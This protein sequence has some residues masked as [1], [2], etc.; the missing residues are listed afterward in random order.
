MVP[1]DAEATI[2]RI[3]ISCTMNILMKLFPTVIIAPHY[4]DPFVCA[5][6]DENYCGGAQSDY[7]DNQYCRQQT[8]LHQKNV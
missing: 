3:I 2:T 6:I 1:A 7:A 4:F 8:Q 5:I